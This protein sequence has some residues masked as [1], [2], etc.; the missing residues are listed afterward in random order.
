[1]GEES[2]ERGYDNDEE[3]EESYGEEG[4]EES[5]EEG[6]E[7]DEKDEKARDVC[8]EMGGEHDRRNELDEECKDGDIE[9][10]DE[11]DGYDRNGELSDEGMFRVC[12][13]FFLNLDI[14]SSSFAIL[15]LISSEEFIL[16]IL[17]KDFD[18]YYVLQS[19]FIFFTAF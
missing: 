18:K 15:S 9:E 1:M 8:G 5:D 11:G 7:S 3:D 6:Y 4:G 12:S 19:Y 2:G 13:I 10:R 14:S 17:G 16:P